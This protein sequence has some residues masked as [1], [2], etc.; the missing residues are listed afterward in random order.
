MPSYNV[1]A[2]PLREEWEN[3]NKVQLFDIF[4]VQSLIRAK[5]HGSWLKNNL[6]ETAPKCFWYLKIWLIC[7]GVV[8]LPAFIPPFTFE[9]I[10]NKLPELLHFPNQWHQSRG[11]IN[12]LFDLCLCLSWPINQGHLVFFCPSPKTTQFLSFLIKSLTPV[13]ETNF[14]KGIHIACHGTPVPSSW[15]RKIWCMI[16]T[17]FSRDHTTSTQ[18]F[19]W[20]VI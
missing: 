17:I 20:L 1:R 5:N 2:P 13:A 12:N 7:Y 14:H 3:Q 6:N 19:F 9:L 16:D 4:Q 18:T 10:A 15:W 8:W 11:G